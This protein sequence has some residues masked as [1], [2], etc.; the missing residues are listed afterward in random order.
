MDIQFIEL[1][2]RKLEIHTKAGT[3]AC[4]KTMQDMEEQLPDTFFRCHSA[5]LINLNAVESVKGSYAVV[6]GK[7]IPISK[8]RRREFL[9]SLTAF[10]G[11]KL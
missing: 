7:L 9:S 10:V 6:A 2:N 3:I 8:H 4:L 1:N 5:F 11:E